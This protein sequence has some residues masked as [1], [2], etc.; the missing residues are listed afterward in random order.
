MKYLA[1]VQTSPNVFAQH[2]LPG[3]SYF[4]KWRLCWRVLRTAMLLLGA[5]KPGALDAYEELIRSFASRYPTRWGVIAHA[6]DIMRS[7]MWDRLKGDVLAEVRDGVYRGAFDPARVWE[8]VIWRS[9]KGKDWWSENI[10]DVI[11]QVERS[12]S[13]PSHAATLL[14]AD[15]GASYATP[16]PSSAHPSRPATPLQ[17]AVAPTAQPKQPRTRDRTRPERPRG[18]ARPP[19]KNKFEKGGKRHRLNKEGQEMCFNWT[20][21]AD[22]CVATGPCPNKRAHCCDICL[23]PHRGATC[24]RK[25]PT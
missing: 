18:G 8:A 16:P 19:V 10:T 13:S 6:D 17:A 15:T 7:E 5:C 9:V 14:G 23:G 25:V 1:F 2:L 3:P 22:G 12:G 11:L 20:R 21:T 4:H 24:G